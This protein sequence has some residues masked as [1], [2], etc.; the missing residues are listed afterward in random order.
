MYKK[1]NAR[2]GKS[3]EKTTKDVETPKIGL[4]I[5]IFSATGYLTTPLIYIHPH[6]PLTLQ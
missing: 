1:K 5:T 6:S 3:R 2:E 4:W